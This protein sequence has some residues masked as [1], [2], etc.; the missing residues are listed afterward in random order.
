MRHAKHVVEP[1]YATKQTL[2]LLASFSSPLLLKGTGI[3]ALQGMRKSAQRSEPSKSILPLAR[4]A[5]TP[6]ARVAETEAKAKPTITIHTS[7]AVRARQ[8]VSRCPRSLQRS[9]LR[10]ETNCLSP[11]SPR[12][13]PDRAR[14]LPRLTR[15]VEQQTHC[16]QAL[17]H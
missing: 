4:L 16:A 9:A 1:K 12:P 6:R 2:L 17:S 13:M 7:A 3:L 15:R 5:M 11:A 14:S 8:G 10:C